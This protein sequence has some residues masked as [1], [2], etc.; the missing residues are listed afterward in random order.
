MF[1]V[2]YE[3]LYESL[4]LVCDRERNSSYFKP[5]IQHLADMTVDHLCFKEVQ[6]LAEC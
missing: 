3:R 2:A 4:R 1:A 6:F 5:D